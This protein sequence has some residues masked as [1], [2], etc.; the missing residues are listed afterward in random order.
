MGRTEGS[1]RRG[2]LLRSANQTAKKPSCPSSERLE[3][4]STFFKRGQPEQCRKSILDATLSLQCLLYGSPMHSLTT[5]KSVLMAA[6]RGHQRPFQSILQRDTGPLWL[7]HSA[8]RF[9]SCTTCTITDISLIWKSTHAHLTHTCNGSQKLKIT[10]LCICISLS[11][12]LG[13]S[14]ACTRMNSEDSWPMRFT[15][16]QLQFPK[17]FSESGVTYGRN[18]GSCSDQKTLSTLPFA[19]ERSHNEV[20]VLTF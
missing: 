10:A 9:P 4:Q 12:C 20:H 3:T 19:R 6:L 14:P 15:A 8:L 17:S 2:K 16:V 1:L 18:E 7:P 11:P 5:P 13:C